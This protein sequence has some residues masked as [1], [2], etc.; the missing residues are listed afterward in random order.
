VN[1]TTDQASREPA[2]VCRPGRQL[3]SRSSCSVSE[4]E[5]H[6]GTEVFQLGDSLR[7]STH[8]AART[9]GGP[10]GTRSIGARWWGSWGDVTRGDRATLNASLA[11]FFFARRCAQYPSHRSP[12]RLTCEM[13]EL[14]ESSGLHSLAS[15]REHEKRR[16]Q[17][18]AEAARARAEAEQRA[19]KEAERAAARVEHER[20]LAE[21]AALESAESAQRAEL[22]QLE[23][24]QRAEFERAEGLLRASAELRL[25]LER[26]RETRQRV[27]LGLTSRLLR[28][29]LLSSAS[30]ALCV[31]GWLAAAGLYFG[32]L[33]PSA[34]RALATAQQSLLSERRTRTEAEERGARSMRRADE[35]SSRVGTLEQALREERERRA[36]ALPAPGALRTPLK[37][38]EPRFLPPVKPCRD[39]GDPLNPCLKR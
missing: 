39:D 26:E 34:E 12:L 28:Q 14:C 31:G 38:R 32:G 35:L 17:Q 30:A 1:T 8:G 24:A 5:R 10:G 36:A 29:R 20:R 13:A 18:Q 16:A 11:R 23:S 7:S 15:L 19:R 21:R 6:G 2:F 33:R 22:S 9:V 27:E 25:E 4:R 3:Q 37:T